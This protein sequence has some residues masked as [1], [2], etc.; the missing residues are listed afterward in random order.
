[1]RGKISTSKWIMILFILIIPFNNGFSEE[2]GPIKGPAFD[3]LIASQ[4]LD[5]QMK[6][7]Q[8]FPESEGY[9]VT[10]PLDPGLDIIEEALPAF[11]TVR[12]LVPDVDS[13]NFAIR[14][15]RKTTIPIAQSGY[16]GH[17]YE[18]EMDD[19]IDSAIVMTHNQ[20]RFLVWLKR[21][22]ELGWNTIASPK[23]ERYSVSL[24]IY[25]GN[26]DNHRLDRKIPPTENFKLP[27]TVALYAPDPE[28]VFENQT[29]YHE[30]LKSH[31]EIN[32][33]I[34]NRDTSFV[35]TAELSVW[36][37]ENAPKEA[38]PNKSGAAFQEEYRDFIRRGGDFTSMKVLSKDLFDELGDGKYIFAVSP[39]GKVRIALDFSSEEIARIEKA[40][41]QKPAVP[42]HAMLFPGEPA[43]TAGSFIVDASAEKRMAFIDTYSDHFFYCN[44]DPS[45]KDDVAERSD[46]YLTSLGHL[47]S[48]LDKLGIDYIGAR[49]SKFGAL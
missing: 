11:N 8:Q 40:T 5:L 13:Y 33:P 19:R 26:I 1:M 6:L 27:E 14:E 48:A 36:F 30:F 18:V 43:L 4:D 44:L 34:L 47:F 41:G 39:A 29:A 9:L 25:F 35:L 28:T 23:L 32:L 16:S 15:T 24:M 17:L 31:A 45:V 42:N 46:H 37:K 20:N 2:T 49:I 12:V 22:T 21:V 7:E 38:Y 3:S 10:G